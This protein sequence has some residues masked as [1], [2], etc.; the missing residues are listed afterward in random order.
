MEPLPNLGLL[1]LEYLLHDRKKNMYLL[2]LVIGGFLF[3]RAEPDFN[4]Y[5]YFILIHEIHGGLCLSSLGFMVNQNQMGTH[6]F[7]GPKLKSQEVTPP[8][9]SWHSVPTW[10][11]SGNSGGMV[12]WGPGSC[13]PQMWC[14][15]FHVAMRI[16]SQTQTRRGRSTAY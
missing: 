4:S 3:L 7:T 14:L 1:P 9:T 5:S 6:P 8:P 11:L 2:H 12:L 13:Q 16:S 10:K 15:K